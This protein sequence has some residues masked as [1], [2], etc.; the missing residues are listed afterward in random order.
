MQTPEIS[1]PL[2]GTPAA[3]S[4]APPPGPVARGWLSSHSTFEQPE[5]RKLVPAVGVSFLLHIGFFVLA[6]L[7]IVGRATMANDVPQE[8]Y[9]IVFLE[10]PG[11]GGGGGGSPTPAPPKKLDIPKPKPAEATPVPAPV[12]VPPPPDPLN[13]PVHTNVTDIL[14]AS[15]ISSVSIA[16]YAGGGSGGGIG[17]GK[18]NGVGP[19]EGGGFGGGAYQPGAGIE[20]PTLIH[21]EEPKYTSEAMRAKV[22]GEVELD[23]VVM[24]DGRVGDVRVAKSLDKTFGLDQAAI[25]AARKWTFRP[26]SREGKPV[27]VVVRLILEFRLH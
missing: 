2:P 25:A 27:P 24:P 14:Q 19:G 17:S 9:D 26:G 12:P 4:P 8:H 20:N 15:G 22:Q 23:V 3:P 1:T 6:V 16:D 5:K 11:P 21:K 13:A 10:A 7:Y 18:G